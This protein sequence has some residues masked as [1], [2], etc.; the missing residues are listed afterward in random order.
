[1]NSVQNKNLYTEHPLIPREQTYV[2]ERK[3][4]TIHSEDRDVCAWPHSSHFEITL[5]QKLT[6]VQSIRLVESNFP[7][8]NNVFTNTNQNTKLT[9]TIYEGP[10]GGTYAGT[11]NITID[12]GFYTPIHLANEL[13]N[14]MNQAVS[15]S[16]RY[17]GFNVIYNEVNQKLWFGNNDDSFEL[18]FDA[19]ESYSDTS[20]M[21]NVYE[22]CR[23]LPPN[24]L[25]VCMNTKWGLPYYLGFNRDV[26]PPSIATDG[27]N[28]EYL[29][30]KDSNYQWLKPGGYY[31]TAP[32]VISIIGETVFYM[33]LFNYND[34]DELL[35]Y[36]RRVNAA[37]NNSY[38]GRVDAAFAK[39][40]ILGINVS[41]YFDSR[42]IMLQNMSQF[43]PP[44]ERV[45]KVKIRLRYHDGRLVDFSNC[46]FNFTLEFDCYRDEMARDLRLRVPAQYTM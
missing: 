38:G 39:I 9:F 43:F 16:P 20:N 37:G 44:L 35:P 19:K 14:K 1:M 10:Y 17:T 12:E 31:V 11:Y 6:N 26:Y 45:S 2:L 46:D 13:T 18:N 29:N 33:D 30:A 36:P 22:N 25:S 24:E 3:L 5:P 32:N 28:F 23:V 8:V 7:T 34:M 41:Q 15:I 27:L 42:N 4:V 40:P 21:F